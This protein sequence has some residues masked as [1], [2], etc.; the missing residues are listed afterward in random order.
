MDGGC[1]WPSNHTQQRILITGTKEKPT[2]IWKSEKPKCLEGLILIPYLSTTTISTARGWL[3]KFCGMIWL[4]LISKC[5]QRNDPSCYSLIMQVATY[6][7]CY[8]SNIKIIF[9]PANTTSK[10]Q[11]LDLGEHRCY[12]L[13]YVLAKIDDAAT[14]TDVT[15]SISWDGLQ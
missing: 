10:I 13:V 2:V 4:D 5:R 9:L 14:A 1:G 8:K 11:P 6:Q 15:K 3:V 12:F 7:S